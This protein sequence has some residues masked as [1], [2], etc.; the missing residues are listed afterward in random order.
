MKEQNPQ[1]LQEMLGHAAEQ[2]MQ[3]KM[4]RILERWK[5]NEPVE[6]LFQLIFR[7]LRYTVNTG[8]IRGNGPVVSLFDA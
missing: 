3:N 8:V 6:L 5:E 1:I 2:R 7:S 4:R